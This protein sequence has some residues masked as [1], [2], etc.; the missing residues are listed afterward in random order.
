MRRF[1]FRAAEALLLPTLGL[2][3]VA[4][5]VP[6]QLALATHVYVLLV[7]GIALLAVNLRL[8][9]AY[10]QPRRSVVDEALDLP[11]HDEERLPEL[12]RLEREVTLGTAS[13]H[14][15]HFRL[16]PTLRETAANLLAVRRGID[17]DGQPARA[18]AA[19]GEDTWQLVRR[20]VEP[21]ADRLGRGVD[22]A[23]LRA[24][25]DA[26]EAL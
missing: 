18:R 23:R 21:P 6:G 9:G 22:P 24:A 17:L 26:L 4:V 19:L 11:E 12:E 15:L 5:L 1:V 16:R 14:D 2:A 7:A 10:P 8:R 20:D 13:A 25:V 3:G